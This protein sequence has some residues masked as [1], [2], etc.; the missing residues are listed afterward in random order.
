[1]QSQFQISQ[2]SQVKNKIWI[3]QSL[4]DGWFNTTKRYLVSHG[5]R[6][7]SKS[8]GAGALCIL[9]AVKNPGSRILCVRGTQNK[10][11][12]SSLQV[13]KDVI[14]L[15]GITSYFTVTENTLKCKNG[16]VFLFYGAK[17]HNSFKSLQNISLTWVDEA[18]ELSYPA[19]ETLIPTVR[20][21]DS[22]FIITF[23]PEK[24]DDFV[25]QEFV[26]NKHPEAYVCEINYMDNPYFPDVL[27]KEMEYDKERDYPKYLHVW[28]GK[29]RQ[30]KEGALWNR[31]MLKNIHK[32]LPE[33]IQFEEIV[34][35][36]DPS[37]TSKMTS[38]ACG[39]IVAGRIDKKQYAVL[40][41]KTEIMSPKKW[42]TMAV[43]L[44]HQYEADHIVYESNQGG[45]L[46]N[47]LI[48][49]IDPSIRCVSVHAR[50]GKKVR[51]EEILYLYEEEQ[52]IHT[53]FFKTLEFEMVT[54]TG[55]KTEKSPNALDALVYALKNLSPNKARHSQGTRRAS[56][57]TMVLKQ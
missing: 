28:E 27:R 37:V 50:R 7:S 43:E 12:E 1:M 17:N 33:D 40:D 41:D 55:D 30:E 39:L 29:L 49:S 48:R 46:I 26:K 34:V 3:H 52:V 42:A 36:I 45:D 6:G 38:D 56:M 20:A 4:I 53:K 16:S 10:I 35:A 25:Y 32:E 9:Y 15:M 18:T 5:G 14:D 11:S 23:N 22:R 19:W 24:E 57:A 2:S 44:Y 51:A 47:T 8:M 21:D 54:F 31:E 13:L